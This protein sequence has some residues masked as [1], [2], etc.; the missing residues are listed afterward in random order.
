MRA[1]TSHRQLEE[2]RPLSIFDAASDQTEP[3]SPPIRPPQTPKLFKP[4]SWR[5]NDW[6]Y[7][8]AGLGID[9]DSVQDLSVN[10]TASDLTGNPSGPINISEQSI[11]NLSMPSQAQSPSLIAP[12]SPPN[13]V[14]RPSTLSPLLPQLVQPPLWSEPHA[15]LA[16]ASYSSNARLQQPP[17]LSVERQQDLDEDESALAEA[18]EESLRI[19]YNRWTANGTNLEE[20]AQAIENSKIETRGVYYQLE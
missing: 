1:E 16:V 14:P 12:S 11:S 10:P 18:V 17:E 20:L 19:N 7:R 15:H 13:Q 9:H 3:I 2:E 5:A 4:K 8:R 6:I